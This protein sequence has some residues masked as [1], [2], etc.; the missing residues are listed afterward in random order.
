MSA[1]GLDQLLQRLGELPAEVAGLRDEVRQ[2]RALAERSV[3]VALVPVPEAAKL[4][5]ISCATVRRRIKAGDL[6]VVRIGR[7]VRVDLAKVRTRDDEVARLALEAQ[8]SADGKP[9]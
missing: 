8:E 5:G 6:P 9:S 3:P 2:L 7:S 1:L 4:L